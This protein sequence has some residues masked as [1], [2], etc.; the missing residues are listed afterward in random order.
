MKTSTSHSA[1]AQAKSQEPTTIQTT[2]YDLIAAVRAEVGADDDD[3][4]ITT[5]VHLLNS[6]RPRFIGPA[7]HLKPGYKRGTASLILRKLA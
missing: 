5:V 4:V 7:R 1:V 2:L 6:H 3:L